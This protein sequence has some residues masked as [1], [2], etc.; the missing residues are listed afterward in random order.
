MKKTILGIVPALLALMLAVLA[1]NMPQAVATS[2]APTETATPT[3][4]S[5]LVSETATL[6]LEATSTSALIV[7]ETASPASAGQDPLVT[8]AALCWVGPGSAYDVISSLKVGIRVKLVGRG[9][10]PGWLLVDN[11][12]YHVPCWVQQSYLQIES[13]TN[14]D[15]L[16]VFIPPPTSTPTITLTPTLTP[17]KTITPTTPVP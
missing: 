15:A 7:T 8:R 17:T 2:S 5:G 11:P 4:E 13:G 1:C 10:I 14:L 3:V 16:P 12:I 9:S 6:T